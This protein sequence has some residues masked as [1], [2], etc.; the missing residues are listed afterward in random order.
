MEMQFQPRVNCL[1]AALTMYSFMFCSALGIVEIYECH[2]HQLR[3][4][5]LI[6]FNIL[7]GVGKTSLVH[8]IVKG[9]SIARPAQTIGCTVSLKVCSNYNCLHRRPLIF[10]E[11]ELY[12][13][14]FLF[15]S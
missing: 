9:F 14:C 10:L 12:I 8:L 1:C 6:T 3:F 2:L 4:M 11:I 13:N 5:H 15:L 7:L